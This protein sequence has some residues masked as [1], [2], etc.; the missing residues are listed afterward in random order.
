M[1]GGA[2]PSATPY[3]QL[4]H[5]PCLTPNIAE[6]E[7]NDGVDRDAVLLDKTGAEAGTGTGAGVGAGSVEIIRISRRC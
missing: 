4:L 1:P 6:T 2:T 5:D 7:N 3:P